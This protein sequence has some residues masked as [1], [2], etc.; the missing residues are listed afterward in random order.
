MESSYK[1]RETHCFLCALTKRIENGQQQQHCSLDDDDS[2][3]A[4]AAHCFSHKSARCGRQS[5]PGVQPQAPHTEWSLRVVTCC[6][7]LL[8]EAATG[9]TAAVA[10]AGTDRHFRI[11]LQYTQRAFVCA[12]LRNHHQSYVENVC[13]PG[14]H[15]TPGRRSM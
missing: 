2:P 12:L 1:N 8:A 14:T 6:V 15:Q 10:A 13:R 4:A 5:V 9:T 3:V 7:L 11:T